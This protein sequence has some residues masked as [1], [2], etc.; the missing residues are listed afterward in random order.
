MAFVPLRVSVSEAGHDVLADNLPDDK[1]ITAKVLILHGYDDPMAEPES[2]VGV[3]NEMTK[4]KA[5]WQLVAYG[6]TMHAFT[7]KGAND[8]D[9][10]TV[11]SPSADARSWTELGNFLKEVI[12]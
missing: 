11:Y 8:P 3:C 12:G 4:K 6:N 7:N 2:M 10:G 9:F 5:D 1:E